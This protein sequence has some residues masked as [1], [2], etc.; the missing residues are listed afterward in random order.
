[1]NTKMAYSEPFPQ[2]SQDPVT[3]RRAVPADIPDLIELT[4]QL[5]QFQDLGDRFAATEEGI[6]AGL[7]GRHRSA[8]AIVAQCGWEVAGYAIFAQSFSSTR[9]RPKLIVEDIFVMPG[10]RDRGVGS[11]LFQAIAEQA[12]ERGAGR[13]EWTVLRDNQEALQFYDRLGAVPS[14][15]W[16]TCGVDENAID[17]LSTGKPSNPSEASGQALEP[18]TSNLERD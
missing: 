18:R 7:F 12:R 3:V 5:A 1:M 9:C 15:E 14:P 11:A 4:R 17:A 13:I 6:R 8:E 2:S 10:C 16:V